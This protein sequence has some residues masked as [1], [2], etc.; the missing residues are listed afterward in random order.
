[1]ALRHY[2]LIHYENENAREL[3]ENSRRNIIP[4]EQIIKPKWP[5]P[6]QI[7]A[8]STTRLGGFSADPYD[9]F[10]LGMHCGDDPQQVLANRQR[11]LKHYPLPAE[12]CWLKQEH[13]NQLIELGKTLNMTADAAIAREKNLI[14]TILTADCLP[15]FICNRAGTEVAALHGGWRSLAAGI[16]ENTVRALHSKN[17][18]LLVWLGPAI[19]PQ[20]FIVG[21]EVR[22]GFLKL[23]PAHTKAFQAADPHKWHADLYQIAKLQFQNLGI[24]HLYGGQF[25]THS[26][27][28]RFFSHRRQHPTGRM[29]HFIWIEE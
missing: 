19:G 10:N 23:D 1:M 24:T 26:D 17:I 7:H 27:S 25:C 9:S 29:G 14:C 6:K 20:A 3:L 18:E 5:A 22:E 16:I 2:T 12:P 13:G 15:I 4:L 11:L 8:F 28:K 21:D